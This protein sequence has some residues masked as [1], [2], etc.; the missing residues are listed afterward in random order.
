MQLQLV[1]FTEDSN[2]DD[3]NTEIDRLNINDNL[4]EYGHLV[5]ARSA[6]VKLSHLIENNS[7]SIRVELNRGLLNTGRLDREYNTPGKKA[8]RNDKKI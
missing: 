6:D 1:Y 7:N 3:F 8:E 2:L 5:L 4:N